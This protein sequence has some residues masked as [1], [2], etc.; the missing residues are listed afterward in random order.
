MLPILPKQY[1]KLKLTQ[2]PQA[3]VMALYGFQIH[4]VLSCFSHVQLFVTPWIAACQAPQFV[5][6]S[7]QQYWSGLPCPPSGD[8]TA[9]EIKPASLG[10]PELAGRFFTTTTIWEV[11]IR[12]GYKLYVPHLDSIYKRSVSRFHELKNKQVTFT[13]KT[14]R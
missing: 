7:R 12:P 14:E 10:S 1:A 9:P 8:L 6:F 5:G 2:G 13:K 11:P 4:C 3:V